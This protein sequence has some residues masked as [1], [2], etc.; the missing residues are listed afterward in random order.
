MVLFGR[1]R[2]LCQSVYANLAKKAL[3]QYYIDIVDIVTW[4]TKFAVLTKFETLRNSRGFV[5]FGD[6][7]GSSFV[8]LKF[9]D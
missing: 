3:R 5:F 6:L 1:L 4:F 7:N 8:C 9:Y 2:V